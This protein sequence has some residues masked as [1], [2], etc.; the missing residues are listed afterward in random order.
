MN[1][2]APC[3]NTGEPIGASVAQRVLREGTQRLR[4]RA[5]EQLCLLQ[6]GTRLFPVAAPAPR[7][8]R[9]LAAAR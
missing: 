5:A 3:W 9:W 7:Q 8:L 1:R 4:A 6:P 2:H